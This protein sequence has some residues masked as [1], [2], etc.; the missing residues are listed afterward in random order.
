[1]HRSPPD[2]P[3]V[4]QK[5]LPAGSQWRYLP[6]HCISSPAFSRSSDH[7]ILIKVRE[8]STGMFGMLLR[9]VKADFL[10]LEPVFPSLLRWFPLIDSL[11]WSCCQTRLPVKLKRGACVIIP[12]SC[13]CCG[14]GIL[15]AAKTESGAAAIRRAA[16]LWHSCAPLFLLWWLLTESVIANPRDRFEC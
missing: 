9:N 2:T 14:G 4:P 10:V 16:V 11:Q 1:M 3:S 5:M 15:H 13:C 7:F 12:R 6:L 8:S